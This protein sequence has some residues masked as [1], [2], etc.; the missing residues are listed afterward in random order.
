MQVQA[1]NSNHQLHHRQKHHQVEN[2]GIYGQEGGNPEKW[3]GKQVPAFS[4]GM[5]HFTTFAI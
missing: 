4:K 5:Q 2:A 3:D 1:L